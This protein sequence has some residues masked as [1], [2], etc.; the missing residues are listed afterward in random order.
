MKQLTNDNAANRASYVGSVYNVG[1]KAVK[2]NLLAAFPSKWSDLHRKGYIHIH[3]LDAYGKTYNCLTFDVI[4]RFPFQ[5]FKGLSDTAIIIRLFGYFKTM[6]ADM[7]NEQSGG[8]AF[9]NFDNDLE[10]ILQKLNVKDNLQN[11][12]LIASCIGDF[13]L[14][15]NNTHTRMGQ[16]S[17]YITLNIGLAL[18][19]IHI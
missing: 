1:E 5:Y 15:C 2:E 16:T 10:E 4:T 12:E 14:W 11:R 18:S 19:L 6:F 13:I 8:M 17:Y 7:G 3:D 9:A